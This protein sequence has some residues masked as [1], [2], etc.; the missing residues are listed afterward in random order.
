MIDDEDAPAGGALPL[1]EAR[2]VIKHYPLRGGLLSRVRAVVK[3]VDGVSFALG[4][5]ET[6]AVVGESGCGKSTLA[7]VV[8]QLV[9][10]DGGD[11]RLNGRKVQQTRSGLLAFRRAV[12]VVQQDPYA[13][14]NPQ[15]RAWD[16]VTEP[17]RNYGLAR[18]RDE[19]RAVAREL[20][21]KVGL[22][23]DRLD[24]YPFEFSGGQ[25]QRLC[26]ARALSLRPQVIVCDEAVSALDVSV[27]AQILGLLADL[28]SELGVSYLFISHDL[29]VVS[30]ISHRVL[31]MYLGRVVEEADT[32]SFFENPLHPYSAA[33]LAAVP[34]PDPKERMRKLVL[35]GEPP[36]PISPPP[37]C[38]FHTRCAK[39][40]PHCASAAPTLRDVAP[41]HRVACHLY[42]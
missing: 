13:S 8:L 41:G 19:R 7:K 16:A 38:H 17:L 40:M 26:I 20:F 31:V 2:E 10:G 36:S 28:Q 33:L 15:Q 42:S 39:A 6:L 3:A 21:H 29:A 9:E 25:R 11:V 32:G 14:L 12:Q 1:L 24:S 30:A 5:G 35:A 34:S 27:Q 18:G 22:A 23:A 37:G 4:E